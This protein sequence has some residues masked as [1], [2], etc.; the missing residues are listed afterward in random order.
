[1]RHAHIIHTNTK[2]KIKGCQIRQ[3]IKLGICYIT[4]ITSNINLSGCL[5][6]K[7]RKES[8]ENINQNKA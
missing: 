2:I 5:Q 6:V 4:K 8:H 3:N 7:H 1:M